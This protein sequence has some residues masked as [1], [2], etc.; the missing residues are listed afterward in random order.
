MSELQCS[1]AMWLRYMAPG[2]TSGALDCTAVRTVR[3]DL[4]WHGMGKADMGYHGIIA[5]GHCGID[6]GESV[7]VG[8]GAYM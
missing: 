5:R 3:F 4:I 7:R 6:E 2:T 8:N 1:V